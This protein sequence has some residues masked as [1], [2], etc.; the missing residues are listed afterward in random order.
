MLSNDFPPYQAV[1]YWF[2]C[3]IER[4]LFRAIHDLAL[5]PDRMCE[6][7]E[8]VPSANI[9]DSQLLK[10]QDAREHGMT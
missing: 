10:A 8:V 9:V 7:R 5:L 3:L 2:G 4:F 1:Y 6:Q